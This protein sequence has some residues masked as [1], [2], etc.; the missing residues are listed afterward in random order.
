MST[1]AIN[2]EETEEKGGVV[3]MGDDP[4]LHIH[5]FTPNPIIPSHEAPCPNILNGMMKSEGPLEALGIG[6]LNMS[7]GIDHPGQSVQRSHMTTNKQACHL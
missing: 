6:H 1:K 4:S 2:M 5:D 7:P 3:D